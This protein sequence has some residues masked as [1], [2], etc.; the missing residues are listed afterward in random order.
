M[1]IGNIASCMML[2]NCILRQRLNALHRSVL[3]QEL[4]LRMPAAVMPLGS[5]VRGDMKGG[6]ILR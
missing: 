4:M 1:P 6:F 2:R 5:D 3:H